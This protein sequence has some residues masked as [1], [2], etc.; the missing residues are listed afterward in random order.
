MTAIKK[1]P[2]VE[3]K[4]KAP[5]PSETQLVYP[6]RFK[7]GEYVYVIGEISTLYGFDS[8]YM[9][10]GGELY[11]GCPHLYVIDKETRIWRIPQIHALR[12]VP[13]SLRL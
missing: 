4:A 11:Y 5:S 6:W 12:K 10:T 9:I 2:L 8:T 7:V 1:H 13:P 3:S